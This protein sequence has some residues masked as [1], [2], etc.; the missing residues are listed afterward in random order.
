MMSASDQKP[1]A[2]G[3]QQFSAL[4][5]PL[6]NWCVFCSITCLLQTRGSVQT[7][8]AGADRHQQHSVPVSVCCQPLARGQN[9]E[10][11]FSSDSEE[12]K[13]FGYL[14]MRERRSE[15]FAAGWDLL[16]ICC[17]SD[18]LF[19]DVSA[20]LPWSSDCTGSGG[21]FNMEFPLRASSRR[22]GG[23]GPYLRPHCAFSLLCTVII[24]FL[25]FIQSVSCPPFVVRH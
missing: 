15:A 5:K 7:A 17:I 20:G 9:G 23:P 22:S 18:I 3:H 16:W 21:S 14:N 19:P 1:K 2:G 11:L 4:V 6:N 10:K 12:E 25:L 8:H 24:F 13:V